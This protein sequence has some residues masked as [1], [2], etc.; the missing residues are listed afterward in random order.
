MDDHGLGVL[1]FLAMVAVLVIF[2]KSLD[3][4]HDWLSDR[5]WRK[6]RRKVEIDIASLALMCGRLC[7]SALEA[8]TGAMGMASRWMK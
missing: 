2:I 7:I 8:R 4:L 5:K 3:P 1:P 6:Y